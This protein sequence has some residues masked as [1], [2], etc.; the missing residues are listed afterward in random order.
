MRRYLQATTKETRMSESTLIEKIKMMF[1]DASDNNLLFVNGECYICGEKAIIE[2]A[3]TSGGFGI[4]GGVLQE[5]NQDQL[6]IVCDG[7]RLNS[8][9]YPESK[10]IK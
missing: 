4:S 3:K 10:G 7:C 5:S 8:K 1:I 2:I 6:N 9:P